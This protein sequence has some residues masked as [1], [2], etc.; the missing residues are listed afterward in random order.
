MKSFQSDGVTY[1][2]PDIV[3]T[4]DPL[5]PRFR[6]QEGPCAGV[7]F[8]ISNARMDDGDDSLL[9]YDLDTWPSDR[10]DQVKPIS[11]NFILSIL[12]SQIERMANEDPPTE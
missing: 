6:I 5:N 8:A 10:V 1:T 3:H 12:I 7:E 9:W 2:I 11:D 4:G